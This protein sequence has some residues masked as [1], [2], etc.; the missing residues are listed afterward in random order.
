MNQGGAMRGIAGIGAALLLLGAAPTTMGGWAVITV[1]HLPERI[2]A[3]RATTIE[4]TIRQHGQAL[5]RGMTPRVI[6]RRNRGGWL[7]STIR[8]RA[9]ETR[10]P[11]SYAA[12][13]TY[14]DT[15]EVLL[16]I[17]PNWLSTEVTLLPIPVVAPGAIPVAFRPADAGQALFVAKGC[18]TCHRKWDDRDL[19]GRTSIPVGPD[20]TGRRLAA[21]YLSV[22]LA[23]PALNR[24]RSNDY[25]VMP[26]LKLSAAEI[27]ALVSYLTAE[28]VQSA[29]R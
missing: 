27:S 7:S 22:K 28:P 8:V 18:V 13:F 6:V 20:L 29:G 11:G 23:N 2:E 14:P 24:V 1:K 9:T 12:E 15:G 17:D 25:V 10:S 4:F 16:T 3:G 5:M 26:D 21:E 19:R